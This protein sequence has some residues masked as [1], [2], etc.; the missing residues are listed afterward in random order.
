M[1][2]QLNLAQSPPG[3]AREPAPNI[4]VSVD[5]SGSMGTT[6]IATLKAALTQT[7]SVNNVIDNRIRL[8]WQ[9]MNRCRGIPSDSASCNNNNGVRPLAGGHRTNFMTWVNGLTNSG[10]TPSHLMI[11]NAGQYLS[12]QTLGISSPWAA[13]P[14]VTQNPVLA[15]RKSYHILMT[16]GGWNG[17]GLYADAN[18]V[19]A[20]NAANTRIVRG[21]NADGGANRDL[22]DGTPYSITSDQTRIYRDDWGSA[23]LSTLSDLSFHYWATDLQ[24][25]LTNSVRPVISQTGTF[26]FGTTASP[27]NLSQYWNPRNNPATWQHMVNYT[28][29]FDPDGTGA[30]LGADQWNGAPVW[31]GNTFAGDLPRLIRGDIVWPTPYCGPD[32]LGTGNLPCDRAAGY[33]SGTSSPLADARKMELWHAALNSR[34]RFVPAPNAAA[35]VDAFN[36]ILSEILSQTSSPLVSIAAS[37]SRLR[38]DGFVYVAGYNTERWSG[39][40]GAYSITAATNAVSPTPTWQATALLDTSTFSV[41]DR[42]V[43]TSNDTTSTTSFIWGS[44]TTV[45]QSTLRGSDNTTTAALRVQYIRGDRS[46]EQ[47]NGGAMR[48]RDSRL[49][50]IVN[51]NIWLT[52][53]PIRLAFDHWQH[54]TFRSTHANRTP[55]LY[56]GANDGMLHAFDSTNGRELMAYVPRGAYTNLREYT[57]PSYSHKYFVDGQPFTGDADLSG[58]GDTTTTVANWRTVLVSGMGA[59]A[60]GFFALNVTSPLATQ[61]IIDRTGS[62]DDDIGHI[63]S[64]PV[65]DAAVANRSEQ[66]VKLNNGRWA[67]VLGNGYNSINERP[68]L[69]IQ[70]LDGDRSLVKLVAN[71]STGQTNG[72]SAPRLIDINGDGKVDIAYAG[73]LLG[74]LWKFN[75]TSSSA[76]GWS[77]VGTSPI[78]TAEYPT[79]TRQPI[80]VA[81]LWLAPPQ[82]GIQIAFGTGRNLTEADR[83]PSTTQSIY[84]LWDDA[85]YTVAGGV[86]TLSTTTTAINGR[87]DLTEQSVATAVT[88]TATGTITTTDFWNTSE[89]TFSYTGPAK[90]RGWYMD[91]PVSGE[92]VLANPDIW[93]G[94]K[95][96]VS[97]TRPKIGASGETCDFNLTADDNYITVLNMFSGKPSVAPVFTSTDSSVN[98]GKAARTRFGS[99]DYIAIKKP[100]GAEL[101]SPSGSTDGSGSC[102]AGTLCTERKQMS[103]GN[104]PG[105]RADW[106]EIR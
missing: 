52:G 30:T 56:V 92:R 23:T 31:G 64:S 106:R 73:D 98:L 82:G 78:F 89:N 66:I 9:S 100:G 26:N 75:L 105:A 71:S 96:L 21:G 1:A 38:S 80:T 53:R 28:I 15:C 8:G 27:A 94:Q 59:G 20:S 13:D 45:T 43:I 86:V 40:L 34:G 85:K 97:S 10:P 88:S 77:V 5:D 63:F 17:T 24:P 3:A 4:I 25:S 93:D 50:D 29:G 72:L 57:L 101:I 65:T 62:T 44:L 39:Q 67:V 102:P 12:N 2:A 19:D 84:S 76:S 87:T 16:D 7:F 79:G 42:L 46:Q 95:M 60:R 81:P 33:T 49:G 70:Y 74:Q 36:N 48:N 37:T 55:T 103:T 91:L 69:L 61:V 41:T 90:K 11:E 35:L 99:G 83:T 47:S 68:V 104:V 22:P 51:S 18:F 14:G 32:N 54:D 6:G 58:R